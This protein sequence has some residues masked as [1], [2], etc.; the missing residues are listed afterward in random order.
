HRER[1]RDARSRRREPRGPHRAAP[2]QRGCDGRAWL[3]P[4]TR[5][6]QASWP[7]EWLHCRNRPA[8]AILRR[9]EA[10][11]VIPAEEMVLVSWW[12]PSDGLI[13]TCAHIGA[14]DRSESACFEKDPLPSPS[15]RR[16]LLISKSVSPGRLRPASFRKRRGAHAPSK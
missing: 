13:R 12:S 8:K 5:S 2:S 6:C 9:S 16:A 7:S 4:W 1:S 10:K 3:L 11:T 15:V 14:V